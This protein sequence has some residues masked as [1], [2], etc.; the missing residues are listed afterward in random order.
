[1][2]T[3]IAVTRSLGPGLDKQHVGRRFDGF[4]LT[5]ANSCLDGLK[6][7]LLSM[8]A[9][10][11]F[12]GDC[13]CLQA[14]VQYQPVLARRSI[15]NLLKRDLSLSYYQ[16][17]GTSSHYV[18]LEGNIPQGRSCPP[19]RTW[20]CRKDSVYRYYRPQDYDSRKGGQR[21]WRC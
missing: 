13:I 4:Q 16:N 21:T 7:V 19:L 14:R 20:R 8:V 3:C 1:M 10:R 11:S 5:F 2:N 17:P 15:A 9:N 12:C 18:G 6:T